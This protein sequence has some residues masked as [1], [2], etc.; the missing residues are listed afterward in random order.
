MIRVG[1]GIHQASTCRPGD[2]SGLGDE[3]QGS[4]QGPGSATGSKTGR[5]LGRPSRVV[6][7]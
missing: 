6:T 2:V 1:F 3:I 7:H 4:S 5:A